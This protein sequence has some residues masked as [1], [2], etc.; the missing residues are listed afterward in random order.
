MLLYYRSSSKYPDVRVQKNENGMGLVRVAW[1]AELFCYFYCSPRTH[2]QTRRKKSK[3]KKVFHSINRKHRSVYTE[4]K[5]QLEIVVATCR[6]ATIYT[7]QKSIISA[8]RIY[9]GPI[10]M[11]NPNPDFFFAFCNLMEHSLRDH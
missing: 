5:P 4:L 6:C 10:A 1:K 9:F 11:R 2:S 8:N 7:T 3:H